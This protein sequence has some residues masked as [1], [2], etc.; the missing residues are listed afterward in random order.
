MGSAIRRECDASDYFATPEDGRRYQI[1]D[2]GLRVSAAP[3]PQHQRVSRRLQRQL[4]DY[5]HERST[6][7]VFN[8]P[9]AVLLGERDVV[10]PDLVV[11]ADPRQVTRRCIEGAPMLLV[12]IL[13]PTTRALDRG[14]KA[15]R[16][17]ALGVRHYWIVDPEARTLDCFRA[18]GGRLEPVVAARDGAR[19]A[20][21]DWD[22]LIIDLELLWR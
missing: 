11:V 6:A 16:Y 17:A 14:L 21:P 12:E 20:H 22:G 2:G 8:A 1:L 7:E 18:R 9:I 5:F 13:S 3:S 15:S 19:L 4:E 10:E